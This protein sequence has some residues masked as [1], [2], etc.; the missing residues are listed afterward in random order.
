VPRGPIGTDRHGLRPGAR[1]LRHD[2]VA[3]LLDT[4]SEP[5]Y[6]DSR[7]A[8]LM[9]T[10]I[11][12]EKRVARPAHGAR[13]PGVESAEVE[14]RHRGLRLTAPR[15]AVLE[16]VRGIMT[17]PTAEEVHRL[18]IRRAPKA[19]LGTVYRNLR[20]LVDAGLLGE[21]PGPR[22]RF[23]GNT[24]AHHHFTCLRCGGIADVEA[25]V[26]EPHSR[27]LSKRV[28]VRTGLTITHHRIN[29][30]GR[31]REC[32]ARGRARPGRRRPAA[33]ASARAAHPSAR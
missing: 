8:R 23:D 3:S 4:E 32:Q 27:A 2:Y 26:A 24:R 9:E 28:E 17:H 33:D 22:A 20:L 6:G 15:K 14:L 11:I 7:S 1:T 31:C 12:A 29:F 19:S 21:L 25:P 13:P 30:F 10:R 5:S 16:V 18:V